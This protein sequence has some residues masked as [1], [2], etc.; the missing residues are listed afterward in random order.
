M[1]KK[2]AIITGGTSGI[3]LA[4]A[5]HLAATGDWNLHLLNVNP[6]SAQLA[7]E[8]LPEANTHKADVSSYES[9]SKVFQQVFEKEGRIDFV[10]AN[11]GVG[12][13]QDFYGRHDTKGTEPPP[14]PN[15]STID[16][17]TSGAIA[18]THLAVHYMRLSPHKGKGASIIITASITGLVSLKHTKRTIITLLTIY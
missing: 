14:P 13:G 17:D 9:L 7:L 16:I 5:Q 3:G 2:T 8:V 15:L 4:T 6:K 18:T 10:F 11:A 1:T 12:E